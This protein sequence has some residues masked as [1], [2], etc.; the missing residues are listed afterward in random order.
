[1]ELALQ[2]SFQAVFG[3]IGKLGKLKLTKSKIGVED[4][5][6]YLDLEDIN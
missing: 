5:K 1:M 4:E 3:D 6:I 2:R